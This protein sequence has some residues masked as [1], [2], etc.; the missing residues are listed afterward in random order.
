MTDQPR[1]ITQ[2][3]WNRHK[4][5]IL[6]LYHSRE[7]PLQSKEDKQSVI[8]I[9]R[10]EHSFL[11]SPSQYEAQFRRWDIPK[12]LKKHEWRHIIAKMDDLHAKGLKT[13]LKVAG[14]I[15]NA[16]RIKR[17]RRLYLQGTSGT[18]NFSDLVPRFTQRTSRF[19][20][21]IRDRNG[22]WSSYRE[23]ENE[24]LTSMSVAPPTHFDG[25]SNDRQSLSPPTASGIGIDCIVQDNHHDNEVQASIAT[26][27]PTT[28]DPRLVSDLNSAIQPEHRQPHN[29]EKITSTNTNHDSDILGNLVTNHGV[30]SSG[31]SP[32]PCTAAPS[33]LAEPEFNEGIRS[34][35]SSSGAIFEFL[36]PCF[37]GP[38][39]SIESIFAPISLLGEP[40]A[41]LS[42]GTGIPTNFFTGSLEDPQTF[43]G[44]SQGSL[45]VSSPRNSP[46]RSLGSCLP[47]PDA[48]SQGANMT[49][50]GD[51]S[52]RAGNLSS[53]AEGRLSPQ[54]NN[55]ETTL[56][57]SKLCEE[58]PFFQLQRFFLNRDS[59]ASGP[60][61]QT[62]QGLGFNR[63]QLPTSIGE[64][65][66]SHHRIFVKPLIQ[67]VAEMVGTNTG[68]SHGFV[69]PDVGQVLECMESLLPE[70]FHG[71]ED[72]GKNSSLATMDLVFDS[73]FYR[74]LL[75]SVINNFA[76]LATLGVSP[77]Y[78]LKAMTAEQQVAQRFF[79]YLGSSPSIVAKPLVDNL[80]AVGIQSHDAQAVTAILRVAQDKTHAIDVNRAIRCFD[81]RN[82]KPIDLAAGSLD[83]DMIEVLLKAGARLKGT[84]ALQ[85]IIQKFDCQ[86]K[87]KMKVVRKLLDEGADICTN[88]IYLSLRGEIAC[89][90]LAEE[91]LSRVSHTS[92]GRLF[93]S[94]KVS[95]HDK[96]C[97]PLL[98]SI[99]QNLSGSVATRVI[100]YILCKCQHSRLKQVRSAD[101]KK[102][103][104]VLAK[105]LTV[106]SADNNVD[107]VKILLPL[108]RN[109]PSSALSAAVR[110]RHREMIELLLESGVTFNKHRP[111]GMLCNISSD[112]L[113]KCSCQKNC[114]RPSCFER[115]LL[116]P[117]SE[118]I[119]LEDR[120]LVSR[121]E[122]LG[123]LPSRY[124]GFESFCFAD[125]ASAAARI[126]DTEYVQM[127]IQRSPGMV[128]T[129]STGALLTATANGKL[130]TVSVLLDA[131]A[132]INGMWDFYQYSKKKA[133]GRLRYLR[134][135]PFEYAIIRQKRGIMEE[136]LECDVQT[137]LA[138][139]VEAAVSCGDLGII[140]NLLLMKALISHRALWKALKVG[141]NEILR[142]LSEGYWRQGSLH[143][144]AGSFLITKA[145]ESG[146]YL[147]LSSLLEHGRTADEKAMIAATE[148]RDFRAIDL[149]LKHNT[150]LRKALRAAVK[151]NDPDMLRFLLSKGTNPADEQS[152]LYAMERDQAA[153]HI[154][155][156]AFRAKYPEGLVGFGPQLLKNAMRRKNTSL[157]TNLLAAQMDANS[158]SKFSLPDENLKR[159]RRFEWEI[160]TPL[161]FAILYGED[162][163]FALVHIMLA[164]G[165]DANAIVSK[166]DP[167]NEETTVWPLKTALLQAIEARN[168]Q[169]VELLLTHGADVNHPARRGIKRTPL[170]MAC[171]VCSLKIVQLLLNWGS[172]VNGA[173]AVRGGGTALQLA[174]ISGSIKIVQLVLS[175]G[176]DV[177]APGS[178]VLGRTA[179]EGAAEHGRLDVLKVIWDAA[180]PEGID[181]AQ[182]T[183]ALRLAR[184]NGHRGCEDYIC[185]LVPTAD[186]P[187]AYGDFDPTLSSRQAENFPGGYRRGFRKRRSSHRHSTSSIDSGND[188]SD[189]SYVASSVEGEDSTD[190]ESSD[191]GTESDDDDWLI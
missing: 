66:T 52:L 90:Q 1:P 4:A 124:E 57:F 6:E 137:T 10:D 49:L 54:T 39:E 61:N 43:V 53:L 94:E 82:R 20:L 2:G 86:A 37:F 176:A 150:R 77:I 7:L 139:Y 29:V 12:N 3:E 44:L 59:R 60:N 11:A 170:Q 143:R 31:D 81:N 110:G 27:V 185:Y 67:G 33:T 70:Y 180:F 138:C 126:G 115:R 74:V 171:E 114:I 93:D 85:N 133:P 92:C 109:I 187:G 154:L 132:D 131:G 97:F 51:L 38:G 177:H 15:V 112:E 165:G 121:L 183:R 117:L 148:N 42:H 184:G 160:T 178:R 55:F 145:I 129:S 28:S 158:F 58:S 189:F 50:F 173:P 69:L 19:Q 151:K 144:T 79:E 64:A 73:P 87:L 80:F 17:N 101:V 62:Y 14:R 182:A 36:A 32:V 103:D 24:D 118:A 71:N 113:K 146:N 152:L 30:S 188:E 190:Y 191:D 169:L 9:M 167:T 40:S 105:T 104:D 21:E 98:P 26:L 163:S 153:Y 16:N 159:R 8:D 63:G 175:R 47:F 95:W 5:T 41:T 68:R 100:E 120:D 134:R 157:L 168:Y 174:A 135:R 136:M 130:S 48:S 76:G 147:L 141:N 179:F 128:R 102:Y 156:G 72:A 78:V 35:G 108:L 45:L 84:Q 186:V 107:L 122:G 116:T 88:L 56:E 172:D 13:R 99:I 111:L 164:A 22:E 96:G 18:A 162:T 161:G 142:R 166:S 65:T 127:L 123:A 89:R 149:L 155:L 75:Y 106:A 119:L 140:D 125:V 46:Y 34:P 91:L 181:E 23:G 83:L 25:T